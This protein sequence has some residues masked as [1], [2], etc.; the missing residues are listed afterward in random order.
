MDIHDIRHELF[1]DAMVVED[2]RQQDLGCSK[3]QG[4]RNHK[5]FADHAKTLNSAFTGLKAVV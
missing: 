2:R 4:Y 1:L 3:I 5:A